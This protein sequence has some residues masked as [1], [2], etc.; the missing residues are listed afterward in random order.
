MSVTHS[1]GISLLPPTHLANTPLTCAYCNKL[2][3]P[4]LLYCLFIFLSHWLWVQSLQS[5]PT[6]CDPMDHSPLGCSVHGILQA[7]ILEWVAIS[8]SSGSS[9][10]CVSCLL[11]WQAGSLPLAPSGKPWLLERKPHEAGTMSVL[12][13]V[14]PAYS[15]KLEIE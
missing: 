10:N 3:A 6:L 8:S 4:T 2:F 14:C 11:H 13:I 7:R 9:Q 12:F 15:T 1:P 5:C